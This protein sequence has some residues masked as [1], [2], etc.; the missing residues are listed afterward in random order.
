M[1]KKLAL[2]SEYGKIIDY[3]D[4]HDIRM[5]A[6]F[7]YE[8]EG[9]KVLVFSSIP[10]ELKDLFENLS[11]SIKNMFVS[12]HTSL[13]VSKIDELHFYWQMYNCVL[14]LNKD[15]SQVMFVSSVGEREP[16]ANERLTFF[17]EIIPTINGF[18]LG[19]IVKFTPNDS[20]R[21]WLNYIGIINSLGLR[22]SV[23]NSYTIP[24]QLINPHGLEWY[25]LFERHELL[26][27]LNE[28]NR[29]DS[30]KRRNRG[31]LQEK[32]LQVLSGYD[33]Y[34]AERESQNT[35]SLNELGKA[36]HEVYEKLNRLINDGS[37]QIQSVSQILPGYVYID[38]FGNTHSEYEEPNYFISIN[39]SIFEQFYNLYLL[40][41]NINYD[42]GD[43]FFS[44][45]YYTV[46]V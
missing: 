2:E 38:Q 25:D 3:C 17:I 46:N 44:P 7:N 10:R 21:Y 24:D 45:E 13:K 40:Y 12:E 30:F 39:H 41:N 32:I 27:I 35:V 8:D 31:T 6:A 34:S 36:A 1:Y 15:I 42:V 11:F 16:E 9:V 4:K 18:N 14:S 19:S 20:T 26:E 43:T 33:V 23:E 37:V 28:T 29:L 22:F 5:V